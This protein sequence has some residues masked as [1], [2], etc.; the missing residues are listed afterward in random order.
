MVNSTTL[1]AK[2]GCY[3]LRKNQFLHIAKGNQEVEAKLV[4]KTAEINWVGTDS[5]TLI[6]ISIHSSFHEGIE[7]TL[8]ME[9]MI[10]MI[11]ENIQSSPTILL[12]EVA[13][14][15]VMSLRDSSAKT[16]CRQDADKLVEEFSP[17]FEGCK[18][19]FW[20]DY[21]QNDSTYSFFR[22]KVYSQYEKDPAFRRFVAEDALSTYTPKRRVLYPNKGLF[23][24]KTKEDLLEQSICLHVLSQKGYKFQTYPGKY[25]SAVEYLA[26]EMPISLI[27][28]FV[29]VEKKRVVEPATH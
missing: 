8:K 6:P 4:V 7:G 11:Q 3:N 23:L 12:C 14:L 29:A 15:Q 20:E 9:A 21:V 22:E 27:H 5:P 1:E 19:V 17:L 2:M 13:H 28:V 25:Y 24:E 10:K 26:R 18:T 16:T